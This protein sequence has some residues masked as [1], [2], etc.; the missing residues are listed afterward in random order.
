MSIEIKQFVGVCFN[1]PN[2]KVVIDQHNGILLVDKTGKTLEA[3]K[4]YLVSI[5]V[6]GHTPTIQNEESEDA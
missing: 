2:G 4:N 6:I 3:G 1:E 5:Q